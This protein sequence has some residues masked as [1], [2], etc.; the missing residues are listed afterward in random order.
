MKFAILSLTLL[1]LLAGAAIA[2]PA[3]DSARGAQRIQVLV[4]SRGFEPA[5]IPVKAGQPVTLV[6]T[7]TTDRTCATEIVFQ[8]RKLRKKLPLNQAVEIHLAAQKPGTVR[9]ACAM[10]MIKGA[11]VVE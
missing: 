2:S 8:G 9:F 11:L 10:N 4:T 5:S 3:A 1:A 6:V 7:R